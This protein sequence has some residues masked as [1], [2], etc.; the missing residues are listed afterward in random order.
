M[1]SKAM[2]SAAKLALLTI[3][4]PA[5]SFA[6]TGCGTAET[7][8]HCTVE[9]GARTLNLCRTGDVITYAFGPTDGAPTLEMTRDFA[10]VAYAP[11]VDADGTIR[12]NVTLFNGSYGYEMF[13]TSRNAG[14]AEGGIIV[15]LPDGRTQTLVCDAGTIAPNNPMQGIGQ[16]ARLAGGGQDDPLAFCMARLT[17]DTAARTCLGQ[18]RESDIANGTCVAANDG[19]NCWQGELTAWEALLAARFSEALTTLT[20]IENIDFIETLLVAQDAW[21]T[22]RDT[23][24]QIYRRNPFAADAGQAQCLAEY[25]AD[26]LTFLSGVIS[27]AE[28]DG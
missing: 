8:M 26:R 10:D 7:L 21:Q 3:F 18:H 22:S 14:I 25:T 12:E 4:W 23:D 24:C 16:L 5:A 28:F 13:I 17:P 2:I 20:R 15:R 27:G 19:T 11:S 1:T 6:Q 9:G